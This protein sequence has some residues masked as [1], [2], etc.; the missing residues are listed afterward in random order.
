M[1]PVDYREN[2]RA[3]ELVRHK[4][5]LALGDERCDGATT[6]SEIATHTSERCTRS[7]DGRVVACIFSSVVAEERV[8]LSL[9]RFSALPRIQLA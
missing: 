3:S 6:V 2:E 5:G 9:L 7:M 1:E 8:A 4:G